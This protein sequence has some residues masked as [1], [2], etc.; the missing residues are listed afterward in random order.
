[1][2]PKNHK[3]GAAKYNVISTRVDDSTVREIKKRIG[4]RSLSKYLAELIEQ[5]L[6]L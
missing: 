5:D 2:P 4:K 6:G 3:S 1:M